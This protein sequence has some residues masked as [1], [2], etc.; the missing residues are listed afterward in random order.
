MGSSGSGVGSWVGGQSWLRGRAGACFCGYSGCHPWRREE[1]GGLI[2]NQIR[3][4]AANR[5]AIQRRICNMLS[6][7]P[8]GWATGSPTALLHPQLGDFAGPI[9]DP[10]A[11]QSA[12]NYLGSDGI[13]NH[14][15]SFDAPQSSSG[16]DTLAA[17]CQS[18]LVPRPAGVKEPNNPS[19]V[20]GL[21]HPSLPLLE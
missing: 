11:R 7:I 21:V 2:S 18:N 17:I 6:S 5:E 10:L 19:H 3:H 16:L 8:L 13:H 14:N 20:S 15:S 12:R 1:A 4:S 9:L